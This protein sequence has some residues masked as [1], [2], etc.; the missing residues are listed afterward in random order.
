MVNRTV[1]R[2][3]KLCLWNVKQIHVRWHLFFILQKKR[4]DTTNQFGRLLV[5][6]KT[7]RWFFFHFIT[8]LSVEI[9]SRTFNNSTIHIL[10]CCLLSSGQHQNSMSA[11]LTLILDNIDCLNCPNVAIGDGC[12]FVFFC[13]TEKL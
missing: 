5:F 2:L 9:I 3:T 12:L 11:T 1:S 4:R 6:G 8:D 13:T 7:S 10:A